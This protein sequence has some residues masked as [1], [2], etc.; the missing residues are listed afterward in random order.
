M[1]MAIS[2]WLECLVPTDNAECILSLGDNTSAVGWLFRSSHV[3]PTS[4]SFD[5]IQLVAR[6]VATLIMESPH[7]IASQHIKGEHNVVSDLLSFENSDRGY[8]HPLAYDSPAD[9]VLTKRFHLFLPTQIPPGFTI[10]PLPSGILSWIT[11]VLQVAESSLTAAK[12]RQTKAK[13]E[14]GDAGSTS[15]RAVVSELTPS[16]LLYT[17]A[18]KN[19]SCDPSSASIARL[20]GLGMVNLQEAVARPWL[21]ALCGLPQAVWLRRSGTIT[22]QPLAPREQH[23]PASCVPCAP[24]R[25]R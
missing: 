6:T 25:L 3:D 9:N 24:P 18:S 19:S 15:A 11:L 20:N 1:G 10:S 23:Q 4:L 5:A 17:P 12:K 21:A 7:C 14:F 16:S 22:G 13:T 2:I 8:L